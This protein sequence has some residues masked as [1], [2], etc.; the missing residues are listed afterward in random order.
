MKKLFLILLALIAI[1]S[2]N[3][4]NTKTIIL[5]TSN[6]AYTIIKELAGAKIDV[7]RLIPPGASPHTYQPKPS[8]AYKAQ[9]ANILVYVADNNDGWAVSLPGNR[10]LLQLVELLPR[11]FWINFRGERINASDTTITTKMIDT[12]F[13][14]DPLAVKALIFPLADTLAKLDHQNAAT[15]KA[16]AQL[17]ANRLDILHRQVDNIIHP[18]K[19]RT[20]FLHHPSILYFIN[21]YGLIYGGAIEEAPGKE[22][23]P[24]YIANIVQKIKETN[25]KAIFNEPQLSDKAIKT[26]AET[27]NVELFMLDPVGGGK[28]TETYQD[29]ILFNAR[30]LAKALAGAEQ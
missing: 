21:R 25:T 1:K 30:T 4:Q 7:R 2:C 20:V 19:G 3:A 16:N 6:P 9:S 23:S 15:Y 12:H 26:I 17:F 10:K 22:P 8:D 29:L 13:W 14:M 5:V 28:G 24:K 18:V 27:A 11:E